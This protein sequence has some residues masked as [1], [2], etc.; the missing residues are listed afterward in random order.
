MDSVGLLERAHALGFR[1]W[2]E[3]DQLRVRGHK[4][5]TAVVQELLAHKADV[6]ALLTSPPPSEAAAAACTHTATYRRPSDVL[7]CLDCGQ[8]QV[9]GNSTWHRQQPLYCAEGEHEPYPDTPEGQP[10]QCMKCPYVWDTPAADRPRAPA[11]HDP[12]CPG[13]G[14]DLRRR[15]GSNCPPWTFLGSRNA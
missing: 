12:Q 5:Y 7:V 6:I 3:G 13:N 15:G 8:A 14:G 2:V 11:V 9:P 4:A 10:R 1:V